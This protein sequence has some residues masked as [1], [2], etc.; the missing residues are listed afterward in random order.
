[1]V[2]LVDLLNNVVRPRRETCA[3]NM[4]EE[5]KKLGAQ[6]SE[7]VFEELGLEPLLISTL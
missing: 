3:E 4:I 1:M 6:Y 7:A 5:I 2:C